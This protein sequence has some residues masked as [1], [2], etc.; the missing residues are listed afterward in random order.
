MRVICLYNLVIIGSKVK[1]TDIILKNLTNS[2]NSQYI[3]VI[4]QEKEKYRQF[5]SSCL[6]LKIKM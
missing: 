2:L 1:V 4:H 6:N 5:I 3:F